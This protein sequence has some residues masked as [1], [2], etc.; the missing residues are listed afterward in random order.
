MQWLILF[1]ALAFVGWA[2]WRGYEAYS[3]RKVL[4]VLDGEITEPKLRQVLDRL[5]AHGVPNAKE[6]WHQLQALETRVANAQGV[7]P[8]LKAEFKSLLDAKAT[9]Y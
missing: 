1:V 5:T 9:R 7:N 2:A 3:F 6:Y 4:S 8:G